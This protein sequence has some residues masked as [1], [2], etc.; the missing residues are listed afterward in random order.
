[1]AH[2]SAH[3][4]YVA[5][6]VPPHMASGRPPLPPSAPS[7]ASTT[8]ATSSPRPGIPRNFRE[9]FKFRYYTRQELEHLSRQ[10]GNRRDGIDAAEEQKRRKNYCKWLDKMVA[11]LRLPHIV[12]S[13]AIVYMHRYFA[14][15]VCLYLCLYLFA[16]V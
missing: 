4:G 11:E 10:Q 8:P 15:K 14:F 5:S 12:Y 16:D 13:T 1:M 7:R 2:I 9:T 6:A 3:P